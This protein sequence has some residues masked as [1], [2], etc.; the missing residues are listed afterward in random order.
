MDWSAV[1]VVRS[2]AGGMILAC[3]ASLMAGTASGIPYYYS[4]QN[5]INKTKHQTKTVLSI[6]YVMKRFNELI[7]HMQHK[8]QNRTIKK[9]TKIQNENKEDTGKNN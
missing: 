8:T 5:N 4:A 7:G 9:P 1:L 2:F 6:K 3:P